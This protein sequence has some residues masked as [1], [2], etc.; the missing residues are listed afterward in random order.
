MFVVDLYTLASVDLLDL[1]AK[2]LLNGFFTRHTKDVVRY[3]WTIDQLLTSGDDV[4]S[5]DSESFS[6][7]HKVFGFDSTFAFH[8][9][10]TLAAFLFSQKFN[11]AIDLGENGW[12][13]WFS[14]FENFGNTR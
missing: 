8:D 7:R 4:A 13:F 14:S 10:G 1:V 5:V 11:D 2:V 9:D 6:W 3:Q 12:I